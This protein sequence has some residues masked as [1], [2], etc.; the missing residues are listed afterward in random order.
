[1][2][3]MWIFIHY[4]S[5]AFGVHR[6]SGYRMKDR[7]RGVSVKPTWLIGVTV[8]QVPDYLDMCSYEL[9]SGRNN[10]TSNTRCRL[11]REKDY[12]KF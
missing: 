4:Q 11:G 3:S 5:R 12:C 2:H 10:D 6:L 1:M 8:E 9:I 7:K